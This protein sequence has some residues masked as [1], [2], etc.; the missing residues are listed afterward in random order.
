MRRFVTTVMIGV[1]LWTGTGR[2]QQRFATM[3]D[4]DLPTLSAIECVCTE[5]AVQLYVVVSSSTTR[6]GD[7]VYGISRSG[8]M[9]IE[10]Q[11]YSFPAGT[12][13]RGRVV[14]V[15]PSA[16]GRNAIT[17]RF[18]ELVADDRVYPIDGRVTQVMDPDGRNSLA[19]VLVDRQGTLIGASHSI[20]LPRYATLVVKLALSRR[21]P[22]DRGRTA[23]RGHPSVP[24]PPTIVSNAQPRPS[25]A[26]EASASADRGTQTDWAKGILE[27]LN[28]LTGAYKHAAEIADLRRALSGGQ[29][30]S[31]SQL[32][33]L[34][35]ALIKTL[36]SDPD[37]RPFAGQFQDLLEQGGAPGTPPSTVGAG[38]GGCQNTLR[39]IAGRL[40]Q[41][42][43]PE[44]SSLRTQILSTTLDQIEANIQSQGWPLANAVAKTMEQTKEYERTMSDSQACAAKIFD[45]DATALGRA[46]TMRMYDATLTTRR[47]QPT[48]IRRMIEG[49]GNDPNMLGACLHAFVAADMGRIANDEAAVQLTCRAARRP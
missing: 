1:L 17:I 26:P 6:V 3:S 45:G 49:G 19:N 13:L 18:Y 28:T 43:N 38:A 23:L 46:L 48:S 14:N 11:N 32:Q 20:E 42:A 35:T 4:V 5:I 40:P 8:A 27:L 16:Q 39:H 25:A 15:A 31:E 47:G 29:P 44:L 9:A 30:P 21:L 41:F 24:A 37:M 10:G 2:A 36:E 34:L 22:G 7:Y 33:L 12:R